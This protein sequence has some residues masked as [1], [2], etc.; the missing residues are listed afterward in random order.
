VT[1]VLSTAQYVPFGP[2]FIGEI[3]TRKFRRQMN[4]M[5]RMRGISS[6]AEFFIR[7]GSLRQKTGISDAKMLGY[8][9][10][11]VGSKEKLEVFL[12]NLV[13][14]QWCEVKKNGS[15]GRYGQPDNATSQLVYSAEAFKNAVM[16]FWECMKRDNALSITQ[17]ELAIALLMEGCFCQLGYSMLGYYVTYPGFSFADY[18]LVDFAEA[19]RSSG[20]PN[21][22]LTMLEYDIDSSLI[23]SMYSE[24]E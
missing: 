4:A 15:S 12:Y 24:V 21:Q 23:D 18:S 2:A 22:V 7:H 19:L 1:I 11:A 8:W 13:V 3:M 20:K 16:I 17:Q 9:T 6:Y 5:P 10:K 14:V